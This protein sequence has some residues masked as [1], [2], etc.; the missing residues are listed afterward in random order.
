MLQYED[1]SSIALYY[2][3]TGFTELLVGD[4]FNLAAYN[5]VVISVN[6]L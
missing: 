1:D 4:D 3:T 2:W 6:F 5:S